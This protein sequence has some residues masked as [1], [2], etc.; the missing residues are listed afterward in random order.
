VVG[1]RINNYELVAVLG[2]G[3]MGTVYLA[4]HRFIGRQAAI[5]IMRPEL[6]QDQSLV[7]RL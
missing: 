3:G 1:L 4:R 2:Q 5:K 6:M 7:V